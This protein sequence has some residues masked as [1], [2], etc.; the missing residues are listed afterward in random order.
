MTG[1]RPNFVVVV[2]DD[3]GQWA[4]PHRCPDLVA[5]NLERLVAEGLEFE[6]F[7]CA[8]PVCSPARASLLTGM[9]PS[10]HGVH[11]WIRGEAYG[12]PEAE[13]FL[14]GLATTPEVL[15]REGWVCGH[16]GK[17]HLGLSREPAPGFSFWYAH[18]TGD[19]PYFGA[20]VWRDGE[21]VTEPRYVTDAITEEA[22]RFLE[23]A[24]D[25]DAPFFL[26]VHYTAP[27]SPWVG[28]HPD[29][30]LAPYADSDFPSVPREEAHPWFSWEPGPVSD[31]MRDPL[32][33]LEGYF[34]SLTG[35]DRGI[36]RLREALNTFGVADDTYLVFTSDNGFSCGHHGIWGKG[37]ATWP[38]NMWENSVR[39]PFV[40]HGPGTAAGASDELASAVDLHPTIL[41]LAGVAVPDG[42]LLAGRSLAP[43]ILGRDVEARPAVFVFDEYGGTR[44]V[45][46]ARWKY[47][48]RLEGPDE[49]YDL[50]SDPDE[51]RNLVDDTA[52]SGI[53]DE[54]AAQLSAWF[55]RHST[56]DRDAFH[57]PVSGRGQVLPLAHGRPDGK[58]YNDGSEERFVV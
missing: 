25:G 52:H 19:G 2:T 42:A 4:M 17:W 8:S 33:G 30:L 57:R 32:P 27:H 54:L 23:S 21:A 3:Q 5:P 31:A 49:L 51:R 41:E 6:N 44:M 13:G 50:D 22:V 56:A 29:E 34:A 24:A 26:Q 7:F 18:R 39:V 38:L 10:A 36:G 43:W 40:V 45:R 15:A 1:R 11:D 46:T 37:N 58:T 55:E 47:V 12:T 20:P 16:S 14:D 28:Q 35:V 9:M 53:V 48:L